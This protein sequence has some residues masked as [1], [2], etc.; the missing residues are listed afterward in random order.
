MRL[1]LWYRQ[2]VADEDSGI[3][4]ILSRLEKQRN[5]DLGF[6]LGKTGYDAQ[7]KSKDEGDGRHFDTSSGFGKIVILNSTMVIWNLVFCEDFIYKAL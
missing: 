4:G 5:I 3:E 6:N 7:S 2:I 1:S